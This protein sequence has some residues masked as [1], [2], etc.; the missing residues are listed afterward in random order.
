MGALTKTYTR[1]REAWSCERRS[2]KK[3][4][5]RKP[6]KKVSTS[7]LKSM[8]SQRQWNEALTPWSK[9]PLAGSKLSK[10]S[11][12][13]WETKLIKK[14]AGL[15]SIQSQTKCFMKDFVKILKK[16]LRLWSLEVKKTMHKSLVRRCRICFCCS[17]S[18]RTKRPRMNS[19]RWPNCGN[20]LEEILA[21]LEKCTYGTSRS[22]CAVFK[23]ST[24]TGW[25]T[26]SE[27]ASLTQWEEWTTINF[28]SQVKK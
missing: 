9:I 20:W 18:L 1:T 19:S 25:S 10:A 2:L 6:W 17:D 14:P 27:K 7:T 23:T 5:M 11:T 22:L 24:L 28:T 21:A 3:C 12:R 15:S 4:W 26:T 13:S 8:K 16:P